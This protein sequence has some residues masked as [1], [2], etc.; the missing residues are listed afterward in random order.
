MQAIVLYKSKLNSIQQLIYRS[1]SRSNNK[2]Q[3]YW[4]KTDLTLLQLGTNSCK[5]FIL[6]AILSLR[7]YTCNVY[8]IS[9]IFSWCQ[10]VLD[11]LYWMVSN[12]R[13]INVICCYLE[14]ITDKILI[15]K[16]RLTRSAILCGSVAWPRLA[17][18]LGLT[19]GGCDTPGAGPDVVWPW[20]VC[21]SIQQ[22]ELV[23]S[24]GK[25][26]E[27]YIRYIRLIQPTYT[28]RHAENY[29]HKNRSKSSFSGFNKE[30]RNIHWSILFSYTPIN[31][32]SKI[33]TQYSCA[34]PNSGFCVWAS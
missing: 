3:N 8:V 33:L 17:R 27:Q 34:I 29:L 20:K 21:L 13:C 1:R 14:D 28:V 9:T 7:N 31:Y 26:Q 6:S 25:R 15:R 4:F 18:T 19:A 11:K 32:Q 16:M 12:I 24:C 2:W 10:I 22:L 5:A 30:N 23:F